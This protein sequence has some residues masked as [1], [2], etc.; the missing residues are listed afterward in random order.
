LRIFVFLHVLT[1]FT[2]VAVSGGIDL[3]LLRV[4]RS[5]DAHTIR[6]VFAAHSRIEPLIPGLFVAGLVF[7]LIAI[8][9]EGFNPF[10][11][12]LL[13]AYPLFVA[14]ILVGALGMGGWERR[15][16]TVSANAPESGSPALEATIEDRS[17]R[18]WFGAFWLIIAAIIFVMVLKPLS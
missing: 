9:V 10:Q 18:Y 1:M 15:M 12:W 11:P 4:A 8:F 17:V 13:L 2:A 7:G 16:R 3:L 5:R 14:G 6:T